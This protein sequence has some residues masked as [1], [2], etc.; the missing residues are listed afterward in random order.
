M[1]QTCTQSSN[2]ETASVFLLHLPFTFCICLV[3]KVCE[4]HLSNLLGFHL[5]FHTLC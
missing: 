3:L 5:H 2:V 4:H 1:D